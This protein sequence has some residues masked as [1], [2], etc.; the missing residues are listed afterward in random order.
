MLLTLPDAGAKRDPYH[1]LIRRNVSMQGKKR[2]E[3]RSLTQNVT[4]VFMRE[5]GCISRWS[6]MLVTGVQQ[7]MDH[8]NLLNR[9]RG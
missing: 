1:N 9:T 5:G 3:P 7:F 6:V 8:I 4:F 2:I